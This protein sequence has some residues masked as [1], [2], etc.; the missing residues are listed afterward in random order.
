MAM[1]D[2]SSNLRP[3]STRRRLAALI[4]VVGIVVVAQR[5]VAHWPRGV[6]VAYQVEPDVTE[7]DVDYL[8]DGDAVASARFTNPGSKTTVFH[9]SVKLAPGEY[10]VLITLYRGQSLASED[11]RTLRVPAE[12][13]TRFDLRPITARSE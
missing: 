6:E 11:S 10:R 1:S 4:A 5:L 9:H 7:L 8:D 12:G 2:L 13:Q 3:S